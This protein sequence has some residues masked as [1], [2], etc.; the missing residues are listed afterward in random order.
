MNLSNRV[1]G[2]IL[3]A[4]IGDAMGAPTEMRTREQIIEYFDGYVKDFVIPPE[5]VFAKGRLPGQVTDDFSIAYYLLTEIIKSEGSITD[6]VAIRSIVNWSD[7]E[8]FCPRFA[9]PTTLQAIKAIKSG[10]EFDP[11][12]EFGLVNYNN[13]L[14]NGAAMKI[15]PIGMLRYDSLNRIIDDVIIIAKPTHFTNLAIAGACAVA[16]AV[17]EAMRDASTIE[18]IIEAGIY[19]AKQGEVEAQKITGKISAGPSIERR[20]EWA[21]DIGRKA[22]SFDELLIDISDYIG[23]GVWVTE[24][25][26]AVFGIISYTSDTMT[27]IYAGVNIGSDTDTIATMVG[28][29]LGSLNGRESLPE[30]FIN[31]VVMANDMNI[32]ELIYDFTKLIVNINK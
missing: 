29:I 31:K 7:D 16:C 10:E 13:L 32:L 19:G 9:G 15:F 20:I 2:G 25:V 28:A 22:T 6:D 1:S 4:M 26:P 21:V 30:D 14:T 27:G 23:T 18:S 3:G 5:D 11:A 17:G 24:S 12:K 8:E